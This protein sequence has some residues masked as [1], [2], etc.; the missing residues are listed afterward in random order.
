M[1]SKDG[2]KFLA[3][4]ERIAQITADYEERIADLRADYTLTVEELQGQISTLTNEINE[5]K[6]DKSAVAEKKD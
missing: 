2:L 3:I 5:L 4:K 6:A 1:M